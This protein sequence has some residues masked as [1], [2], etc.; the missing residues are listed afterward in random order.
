MKWSSII[1]FLLLA[2]IVL[3][4]CRKEYPLTPAPATPEF[5]F[6]GTIDGTTV[7]LQAGVDDYYMFTSYTPDS[8]GV[9]DYIG[10]FRDKNCSSNCSKS[11][12]IAFKDY[13]KYA[14]HPTSI[15]TTLVPGYYS[16]AMPSGAPSSF[17]V[18]Y[19]DT[20]VNGTVQNYFW[21]FGDGATS[22]Q[23]KPVHV[24][25]HPGIYVVSLTTETNSCSSKLTNNIVVG[26]PGNAFQ[27]EL[28]VIGAFGDSVIFSA[29][30]RGVF[31]FKMVI[32]YGDGTTV[33][34]STALKHRYP[35]PGVYDAAL[36]VT[37]SSGYTAVTH[38]NAGTQ[39]AT[40]CYT[41]FHNVSPTPIPNPINLAD[42]TI[43]WHDAAGN[44]YTSSNN[45]QWPKSTFEVLSVE[46]YL[47][48]ING[49]PTKKI[50][51]K[52]TCRLFNGSHSIV[53]NGSMVFCVA[54]L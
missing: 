3:N 5:I 50:R 24:Y 44:L 46:N 47:S 29:N 35:A 31:P 13:R 18:V 43:E 28:S 27:P 51:A 30:P 15:D 17:Y 33:T 8:N 10:E 38:V 23:H 41:N 19:S 52:V 54:H 32:D 2:V 34:N 11:L 45:G 40:S 25:R 49:Q 37:D 36:T 16:F 39:T 20:I 22:N 48:N 14:V 1:L 9:Y 4:G 42:V 21:D 26:Q 12:K 6:T 7:N 53:L